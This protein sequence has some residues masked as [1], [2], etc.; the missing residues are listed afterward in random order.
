MTTVTTAPRP[1]TIVRFAPSPT[2]RLHIG[3]IRTALLNWLC[4]RKAGGQFILR[5]DDTD[6]ERST[7]AF[8]QGIETDLT[9][10][11]LTWDQFARQ[12][13]RTARYDAV[14]TQLKQSGRLYACYETP[15]ELD[16]R[17]KRQ[18]ARGLPPV[19]DR[20]ALKLTS[21]E[22]AQFA[23]EGR[24]PHWRFLLANYA[25]D[26]LQPVT[27]NIGWL[28]GVR[29]EQTVDLASLSDPVLIRGDGAY[30][31]TLCSV[32][33]DVDMGV[34]DIIRGEDHVTNTGVQLDIF[35]ALG[36]TSPRF[37]HH[38]LLTGADGQGLSKR[39]G[40]LSIAEF[41]ELGMEPMAIASH[42][43]ALGTSDPITPQAAL[44]ALVARFD[45]AKLSRAPARFDPAELAE[46]NAKYLHTLPFEAVAERLTSLGVT[47]EP[48]LRQSFWETVRGNLRIVNDA[49]TWWQVVNVDGTKG[50]SPVTLSEADR[51]FCVMAATHLPTEPWT[52]ETWGAWTTAIKAATGRKGRDLFHPL[53]LA[54][55][56][57]ESGPEMKALLPLIGHERC[58][59]RLIASGAAA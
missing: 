45:L 22:K 51:A 43:A 58:R 24:Q 15:E 9:W 40:A 28:D 5:L 37:A 35:K 54:L 23:V 32:V 30:L 16:R 1:T 29:G 21:D 8:A 48:A 47:G 6:A 34:T 4:A 53:R 13:D 50:F 19:Y 38:S 10:L 49:A 56:G 27:T 52:V 31:Y 14:V 12:S 57:A 55:T 18:Q 33:D 7:A 26:P 11:G 2:G 41:R 25:S 39:T 46:L 17:R 20:A 44:Y 36:A 3:N 59:S 42:A